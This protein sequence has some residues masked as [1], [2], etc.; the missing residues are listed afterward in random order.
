MSQSCCSHTKTEPQGSVLDPVCGMTVDPLKTPHHAPHGGQEY[1]F[2]SAGCR[3]KFIANPAQYLGPKKPEP[4]VVPGAIYT[5]PMDPEVQQVGPGT[6]PICGMA[7]EPMMP[8]ADA[9]PNPELVDMTKRFWI[10]I[11]L[12]LPVFILEMGAHLFDLHHLIAPATSHWIQ[13]VLAT[14]VVLWAGAPFFQ[15]GWESLK[16]RHFNM[17]TLIALGTGV[18]WLWSMTAL[19]APGLFPQSIQMA[20]GLVPVYFEAAAVIVTLVLVGQV[21]ELRARDRTGTAIRALLNLAPE[22]AIRLADG[23]ESEIPLADVVPGD[24]LRVRPGAKVAVDGRVTEGRSAVDESM[25]TGESMPVTKTVGDS[26]IGGTINGSGSFVMTAEHVGAET[27]LARIVALVASAQRSRAPM[28]RLADRVAGFFVPVVVL[29]AVLAFVAWMLFGP[30]PRLTYAVLAAVS[31]VIIAC[32]CALGLATP[33]SIMV[34]IGRGAANG[35]LIRDAEALERMAHV[36]VVIVDKTGTLTEGRPAVTAVQPVSGGDPR[37]LLE[38]AASVE[39]QSE[40][41]IASAILRA[42]TEQGLTLKAVSDFDSP[43]GRGA[44]ATLDGRRIRIGQGRYMADHGIVTDAVTDAAAQLRGTGATVVYVAADQALLGLIAV[45]DPVK[46]SSLAA[47][48]ALQAAGVHVVM[49]T[50]DNLATA[51]AVAQTLGISD[52]EAEVLPADKEALVARLQ[53]QG[54][55]VAMCGDGV[56]DAPAL[57]RADVGIA[58]GAGTAAAIESAGVTLVKGDL[59]GLLKARKLS[60]ATVANIK[61]N[62]TFAFLYNALGVPVAAGVLYPVFG[63]LL[64][65][66]LAAAAMSL[67]SVSVIANALRLRAVRLD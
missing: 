58:M 49:A 35:V 62:L 63:I 34:G 44:E 20:G 48:Q 7:L 53:S 21:L 24:L 32:P 15:R 13:A 12:T 27:M 23:G 16:S 64:S 40:H 25:I 45:A 66:M 2:C 8:T 1:H 57:A 18:A 37:A 50:G 51:K 4:V 33:M 3:T 22:T 59:G 36:D 56:N 26:V 65:P 46:P 41:P 67:S 60:R 17:F 42:A 10:A 28:Q 19:L 9:G 52:V 54:R 43:T 30:E 55:V 38:L 11:A 14:P 6:C 5:C 61:G 47:V 39:A 29:V 31:V